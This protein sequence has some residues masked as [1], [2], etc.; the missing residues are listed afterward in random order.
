MNDVTNARHCGKSV[1]DENVNPKSFRPIST[2][3][4]SKLGNSEV[5]VTARHSLGHGSEKG[6]A[7]AACLGQA[8]RTPHPLPD[9]SALMSPMAAASLPNFRFV[10]MSWQT[11]LA[12]NGTGDFLS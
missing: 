1:C 5:A 8:R 11:A 4:T 9:P 10:S 7:G 2:P 3:A 6:R 12:A